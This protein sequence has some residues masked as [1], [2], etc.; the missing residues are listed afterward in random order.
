MNKKNVFPIILLVFVGIFYSCQ[1]IADRSNYV[2]D[3]SD[4]NIEPIEVSDAAKADKN[5]KILMTINRMISEGHFS[6]KTMNDDFS[7]ELYKNYIESVDYGKSYFTQSDINEFLNYETKLD[8]EIKDHKLDFQKLVCARLVQRIA[9]T[10]KYCMTAL[11]KPFTF[12]SDETINLDNKKTNWCANDKELE[13][14]WYNSMKYR[15]LA[16]YIELKDAQKEKVDKK[17]KTLTKVKTDT[18]LQEEA[19]KSVK[20]NMESSIAKIKK[21]TDTDR[22]VNYMNVYAHTIDPH[23]DFMPP[24]DKQSFD[25]QMSGSFF[26]IGAVL[27]SEEGNCKIQ[28]IVTGSPCWKEGSLKVGDI[29]QKVA[30]DKEEPVEITDWEITDVVKIIRGKKNTVVKLTTKHANGTIQVISIMRDKVTT[31]ET[32]AKSAIINNATTK[33]GFI[34][35]PEF[36]AD[37]NGG[38]DGRRCAKD[39]AIEIEKLKKENVKGII[40]DLRN[41]GGGSLSDVVDIGGMFIDHGPMVQVKSK[42]AQAE[43]L[44]DDDAGVLYD[45]PLVILINNLSA[46]A[47]EILAAAMQDYKRAIIIGNTSFGKGTVQRSIEM[48]RFLSGNDEMKPLGSLK[49]TLQKFYRINGGSTQL[50]G[51]TPDVII[52]DLYENYE[53]SERK[54]T[55]PLP[56]DEVAKGEYNYYNAG[57]DMQKLVANSNARVQKNTAF[58]IIKENNAKVKKQKEDNIISLNETKYI[59]QL[60][61]IKALNKQ[62]DIALKEK[63]VLDVL[64][65]SADKTY[66]ATA[67]SSKKSRNDAWIKALQKENYVAEAVYIIQDWIKSKSPNTISATKR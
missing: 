34:Y 65:T 47:S 38:P 62:L 44:K 18:E 57:I 49:L 60:K 52:P 33:I 40:L 32:F 36:Y 28:E 29:I 59:T 6:P 5:E 64:N 12:T 35:L 25:E 15:V 54:E 26:G 20:K 39:M 23:T 41:N 1:L 50:K 3:G 55:N 4:L 61:D 27:R 43:L 22:F 8:D 14:R 30:Q 67:D 17:D 10:E 2:D 56:W 19:L 16:K 21:Q 46:S 48:D 66:Y 58:N 37:F 31:E 13:T 11:E 63:K 53:I 24:R 7:K 9:E 51:V 42:S 45:G